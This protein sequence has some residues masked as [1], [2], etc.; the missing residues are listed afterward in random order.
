MKKIDDV[1]VGAKIFLNEVQLM[2]GSWPY[3]AGTAQGYP[4]PTCYALLALNQADA[5]QQR[6][7]AWL[8]GLVDA[9][10]VMWLADEDAPHWGSSLLALVLAYLQPDHPVRQTS[11]DWLLRWESHGNDP[12][13]LTG[14]QQVV[15]WPWIGETVGWVEPSSYAMLALKEAGYGSHERVRE[16]VLL[17]LDR[18]CE[19]GGWNVGH[20]TALDRPLDP[21]VSP[22]AAALLAL[23]GEVVAETAVS[24]ALDFLQA[25]MVIRPSSTGLAQTILCLSAYNQPTVP[26]VDALVGRQL[27]DGSWRGMVTATALAVLALQAA[28]GGPHVFS[29]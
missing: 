19:G 16:G 9:A 22:T 23:Q 10:G 12:E 14:T 18:E 26:F 29:K 15:A 13:M 20:R 6:A 1:L 5:A 2:D 7:V 8:A 24:R 25:E 28:T 17:L 11:L 3:Y 4:E 21:F 27:P